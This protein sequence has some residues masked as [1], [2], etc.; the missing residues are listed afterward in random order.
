MIYFWIFVPKS[1]FNW[2]CLK[3]IPQIL[4]VW[5][6]FK[7]LLPSTRNLT[8]YWGE[9]ENLKSHFLHLYSLSL[10]SPTSP[11]SMLK[12]IKLWMLLHFLCPF[13]P[14]IYPCTIQSFHSSNMKEKQLGLLFFCQFVIQSERKI[15]KTAVYWCSI[16]NN[17]ELYV[18]MNTVCIQEP[19]SEMF[20]S[21]I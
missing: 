20:F 8:Q 10:G 5:N 11:F 13:V 1:L 7:W 17:G 4:H 15:S 9:I 18:H 16:I 6:Q 12:N 19:H 21:L 2:I 3:H 14:S